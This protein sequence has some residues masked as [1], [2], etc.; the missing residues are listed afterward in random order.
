MKKPNSWKLILVAMVLCLCAT[1][2]LEAQSKTQGDKSIKPMVFVATIP[3]EQP[4]PAA[5][6]TNTVNPL[7]PGSTNAPHCWVGNW[8]AP[9]TRTDGSTITGTLAYNVQR[10][11]VTNGVAGTFTLLTATSI[12]ALTYED[13]TVVAGSTYVFLVTATET[14]NGVATVSNPSNQ[15][16]AVVTAAA[17]NPPVLTGVV[18]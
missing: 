14:L 11:L 4:L 9:A 16:T 2:P 18:H 1:S 6:A 13:D 15:V 17:P 10:A 12:P 8:T 3:T 5:G 7:C